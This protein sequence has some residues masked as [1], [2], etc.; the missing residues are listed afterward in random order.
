MFSLSSRF[1]LSLSLALVFAAA[2]GAQDEERRRGAIPQAPPRMR[3][4]R[5]L[6][7]AEALHQATGQSL[8]ICVNMNGE[9]ASERL[10][11][12]RYTDPA[13]AA[14]A[15]G[16]VAV[17]AAPD[18]HTDKDYDEQGRRVPCPRFG[19]VTC[20]EHIA[21]EPAL[22][23]KYFKNNRVA[24]RHLAIGSDGSE[25]FD[26]YLTNDLERIDEALAQHGKPGPP[27]P[28]PR[29]SRA[30][31]AE[32]AAYLAAAAAGRAAQLQAAA[33]S[34]HE[35]YDVIRMGLGE[36][37]ASLRELA[38]QALAATATPAAQA[39]LIEV[40]DGEPDRA[41]RA[42]LLP[43][44]AKIADDK[45]ATK[46]AVQVHAAMT[47]TSRVVA[48]DKWLAAQRE[49]PADPVPIADDLD[50]RIEELSARAV[51]DD[52]AATWLELGTTTLLFARAR[53]AAGRDARFLLADAQ[54]AADKALAKNN[55]D[56]RAHAL[57]AEL[58]QMLGQRDIVARHARIALPVLS[59]QG[60]A[61]A[62]Q[63]AA[64][65][66]GLAEG[67]SAAIY[68]AEAKKAAWDGDLLTDADAAYEVLAAHPHGT[69]AQAGTH[70]DL[71][72]FLGLS[73]CARAAL[74]RAL[75]RFGGDTALHER[76]RKQ[77][78]ATHGPAGLTA[79]YAEL[80][81]QAKDQASHHWFAGYA[82]LVRAE[83]HKRQGEDAPA[84]AAYART[85][86][87]FSA[88]Q[89][90]NPAYAETA[91]WYAAMAQAGRARV[92]LDLGDVATAAR[93]MIDALLRLP[94]VAEQEDGLGRTPLFT[95]KQI[96]ARCAA[97]GLSAV[98]D[99]LERELSAHVP[100][101]WT[102]ATA[103]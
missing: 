83:H 24:P 4:Q 71:L 94:T 90:E 81:V 46:L 95:L 55:D 89:R 31:E 85:V 43:V 58:A 29:D 69:A 37:D 91:S 78:I 48:T 70:A 45:P 35:P 64:V 53:I 100:D 103:R 66:A 65:L 16:F 50:A 99:E 98:R 68:D 80:G 96:L 30:R 87:A 26:I 97:Q 5:T 93:T 7:D 17:I 39:L 101:L 73:G 77:I 63:A 56:A 47:R 41:A 88:S 10:A 12:N 25:L 1:T 8:L 54:Q 27:A 22:F 82:E 18:R 92:N 23:A 79:A 15:A 34:A 14:L 13:F 21:I 44:L 76:L 86:D 32:E 49:A 2:A 19:C 11:H 6:A 52:S 57:R 36:P 67:N 28:A 33:K 61:G 84:L 3:W 51:A 102:K 72:A 75:A 60:A 42:A 38:R 20:G 74:L 59:G 9:P 40:L 62:V